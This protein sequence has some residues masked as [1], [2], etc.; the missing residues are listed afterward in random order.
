[1]R[2]HIIFRY[3][4]MILL[5]NSAFMLISAGIALLNG[6]DTGFYPLL[7]SFLLTFALGSFPMIFVPGG[8][9]ISSKEGYL[10]VVGSWIMACFVGMLPFLLWGG[11]FNFVNSWFESVSG[12]TTTGATVLNDVEALP[13]SMLFWRSSTHWLG[14]VGVVMFALIIVPSLGRTRQRLSSVEMSVMAKDNFHYRTKKIVQILL[15]VYVGLTLSAT[16]LLRIAGMDWFDSVNHAFSVISTG[17]FS[18][19][20]TS[21]AGLGNAWIEIVICIF[22]VAGSL[23]FGVIYATMTGKKNNILRSEVSIYYISVLLVG[24]AIIALSLWMTDVYPTLLSSLRHGMFQIISVSSSSGFATTDTNAWPALTVVILILCTIQCGCAGSTCGGLKC[25]RVL[26]SFKA[27][28]AKIR[29]QQHPNAII[30]IKLNGVIQ[31]D[32]VINYATLFSVIFFMS[33]GMGSILLTACGMDLLSGF[34]AAVACL[35]NVGP[36]FGSVSS[37]SNF[38]G[39]PEA[40]KYICTMLMLLGRLEIFGLLQ[41]FM[42]S[43]WR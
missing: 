11:E 16:I 30:R 5:L 8:D 9:Q 34:S 10:I 18:T 23:H 25:D 27:L 36:G 14:G 21:I 19:H 28:H 33:I 38:G 15:A 22:M 7:L 2:L 13:H 35:S 31:E 3:M 41:I 26:L 6:V 42:I 40:A 39:A 29:L 32:S 37:M 1:M 12:F 24:G 20:N 17:G 4:G 43:T